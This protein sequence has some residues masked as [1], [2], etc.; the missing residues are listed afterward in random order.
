MAWCGSWA[1]PQDIEWAWAGGSCTCCSRDPS[2]RSTR[3]RLG[4]PGRRSARY[5]NLNAVQGVAE[6]L[7]PLAQGLF[8]VIAD[9]LARFLQVPGGA[10]DALAVAG[11][12]LFVDITPAAADAGMRRILM[13]VLRRGDPVAWNVVSHLLQ[14]GRIVER[15]IALP[16]QVPAPAACCPGPADGSLSRPPGAR[17][18]EARR[19]LSDSRPRPP[20]PSVRNGGLVRSMESRAAHALPGG[21]PGHRPVHRR[22][23]GHRD[24]G[25]PAPG[26]LARR[27]AGGRPAAS[28]RHPRQRH[29]RDGPEA[30]GGRSR[31]RRRPGGAP[32]LSRA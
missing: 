20:G 26:E 31:H 17:R 3:C 6:P 1:A 5:F 11:G 21:H 16:R 14:Q 8:R 12:R 13:A 10:G 28:S 27:A 29:H 7:T 24:A 15:E 4:R 22:G 23:P 18:A 19:G 30:M 2:P 32:D 9:G 25:G